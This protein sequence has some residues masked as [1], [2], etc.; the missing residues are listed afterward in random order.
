MFDIT[1]VRISRNLR[2]TCNATD[3]WALKMKYFILNSMKLCLDFR[4]QNTS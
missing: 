3:T 2:K 4:R 1:Q